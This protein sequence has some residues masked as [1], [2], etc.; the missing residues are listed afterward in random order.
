MKNNNDSSLIN[1]FC[2]HQQS[3][4]VQLKVEDNFI[5][6]QQLQ[7][8]AIKQFLSLREDLLASSIEEEM[9]KELSRPI[10]QPQPQPQ[11]QPLFSPEIPIPQERFD[12]GLGQIRGLPIVTEQ[13]QFV[14]GVPRIERFRGRIPN[15]DKLAQE[16]RDYHREAEKANEAALLKQIEAL[17]NIVSQQTKNLN[18]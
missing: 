6:N 13:P 16:L 5:A 9:R 18:S 17:K 15:N 1:F 4:Q 7:V 14:P 10:L 8:F 2:P 3:R 11:P 12:P